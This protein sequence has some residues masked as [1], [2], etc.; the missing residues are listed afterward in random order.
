MS[1]VRVKGMSY[2]KRR[3]SANTRVIERDGRRVKEEE[4]KEEEGG[5]YD[6]RNTS[7]ILP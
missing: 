4:K 1:R 2:L 6:A 7:L 5:C 3:D